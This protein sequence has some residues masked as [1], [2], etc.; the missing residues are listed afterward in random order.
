MIEAVVGTAIATS[1]SLT[2]D[3]DRPHYV[4]LWPLQLAANQTLGIDRIPD[5]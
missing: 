1:L 3:N 5:S 4:S 2:A